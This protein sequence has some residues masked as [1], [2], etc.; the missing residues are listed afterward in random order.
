VPG[1]NFIAT[2]KSI[3]FSLAP[4]ENVSLSVGTGVAVTLQAML[5][6]TNA[7]GLTAIPSN[8]NSP[9]NSINTPMP[10]TSAIVNSAL[11]EIG[12]STTASN[13]RYLVASDFKVN[14]PSSATLSLNNSP[15]KKGEVDF[16]N[17][18]ANNSIKGDYLDLGNYKGIVLV[19][20]PVNVAFIG[21]GT[22]V[23]DAGNGATIN[24]SPYGDSIIVA[25]GGSTIN[26]DTGFDKVIL[27]QTNS[28]AARVT[29]VSGS[30]EKKSKLTS[31]N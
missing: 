22:E 3:P 12:A 18:T 14:N 5:P 1:Q 8:Y 15:Q 30:V 13:I 28:T 4:D 23:I 31:E 11:N 19:S 26:G 24:T 16:V 6:L 27:P 17:F 7:A 9:Y 29:I 21:P 10:L 20:G 2:G 25:Q